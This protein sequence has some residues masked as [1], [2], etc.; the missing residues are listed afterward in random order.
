M[1]SG[2]TSRGGG[3][4]NFFLGSLSL[5]IFYVPLISYDIIRRPATAQDPV[6]GWEGFIPSHS[7]SLS[8][9]STFS[10]SILG[11]LRASSLIPPLFR[12]KLR[13]WL[14]PRPPTSQSGP[15]TN[16]TTGD[17]FKR[18]EA[19]HNYRDHTLGPDCKYSTAG[20]AIPRP[21]TP[22]NMTPINTDSV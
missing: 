1:T 14:G 22:E 18:K 8:S 2:G 21:W 11:A 15:E 12:P 16:P 6:V 4:K 19:E 10:I 3:A 20:L 5:A 17:T 9:L 13:P 7:S